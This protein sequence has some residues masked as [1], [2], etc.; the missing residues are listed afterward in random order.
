MLLAIVRIVVGYVLACLLA[1]LALVLHVVTPAELSSLGADHL[2][3]RLFDLGSLAAAAATYIA[4]FALPF[5]LIVA[6]IGEW[7]ALRGALFYLIAAAAI[8]AAGFLAQQASEAPGQSTIVNPFAIQ[9]FL[10][11]GLVGGLAYWLF[12]GR[13]AGASPATPPPADAAKAASTGTKA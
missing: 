9:A 5:A 11:T 13:Y 12:A 4:F 2:A 8:A 7:F 3:D 1:G 6:A 10:I